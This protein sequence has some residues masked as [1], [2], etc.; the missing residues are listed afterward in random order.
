MRGTARGV[1]RNGML[2]GCASCVTRPIVPQAHRRPEF[3]S[4][5]GFLSRPWRRHLPKLRG[6]VQLSRPRQLGHHLQ[7]GRRPARSRFR[8]LPRSWS[9]LYS[10]KDL[11]YP[12]KTA[13]FI[14]RRSET[15]VGILRR[16]DTEFHTAWTNAGRVWNGGS[17][18]AR[19]PHAA[20]RY[21]VPA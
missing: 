1:S 4:R 20:R 3:L 17:C 16:G 6:L 11:R 12:E 21:V 15:V 7:F 18:C 5:P 13:D 9:P 10:G 8:S 14:I 2:A 19:R